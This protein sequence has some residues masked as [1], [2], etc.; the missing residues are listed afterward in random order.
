MQMKFGKY[1]NSGL[2]HTG[3]KYR[4]DRL[5]FVDVPLSRAYAFDSLILN[6]LIPHSVKRNV[7]VLMLLMCFA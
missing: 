6:V 7:S 1:L 5:N 3:H 2:V 4:L